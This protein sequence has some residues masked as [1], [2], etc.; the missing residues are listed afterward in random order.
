MLVAGL[1]DRNRDIAHM[2]ARA[3]EELNPDPNAVRPLVDKVIAA[4][5]DA[6]DRVL[7]AFA[8]LGPAPCR[9]RWRR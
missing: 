8:S 4:N 5:P 6:A 2:A 1:A 9:T 3:L 7:Q